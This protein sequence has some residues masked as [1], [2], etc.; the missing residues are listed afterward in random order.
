MSDS[1]PE[2]K[3]FDPFDAWRGMRDASLDAWSKTMIEAVNTEAYAKSSGA[4]LDAWLT[5]SIPFREMLEKTM[6]QALQQLSM[7]TRADIISLAERLTNIE[8]KLDDMDARLDG[9]ET[10]GSRAKPAAP[11]KEAN[12]Q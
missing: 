7:P 9:M 1:N 12:G 5:A 4:M 11:P 6:V 10:R 3:N 2:N 8:M